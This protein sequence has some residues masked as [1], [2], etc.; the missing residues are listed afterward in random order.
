[1][2]IFPVLEAEEVAIVIDLPEGTPITTTEEVTRMI[3]E[4]LLNSK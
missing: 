3:E 2:A 4:R 1:M